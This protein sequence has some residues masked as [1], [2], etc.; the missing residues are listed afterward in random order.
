[1]LDDMRR[2][3]ELWG[4]T[5]ERSLIAPAYRAALPF[6]EP[7][8]YRLSTVIISRLSLLFLVA[9]INNRIF[10][11]HVESIVPGA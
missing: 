5:I 7:F 9:L 10:Y 8:F 4:R 1:M 3:G 6:N 2:E 11:S